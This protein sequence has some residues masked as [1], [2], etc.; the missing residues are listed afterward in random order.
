MS[1]TRAWVLGVVLLALAA[2]PALGQTPEP[3]QAKDA[4]PFRVVEPKGSPAPAAEVSASEDATPDPAVRER[5]IDANLE[6]TLGIYEAILEAERSETLQLDRRIEQNEK[7]VAEYMPQLERADEKLRQLQVNFMKKTFLLKS[8]LEQGDI[9]KDTFN[10]LMEREERKNERY[11]EEFEDDRAFFR[12]EIAR[13]QERLKELRLHRTV[14]ARAALLEG[15][16]SEKAKTRAAIILEDM[17]G[18]LER[19]S[20]FKTRYPMDGS[21]E[22]LHARLKEGN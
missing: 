1:S 11:R 18:L 10:R 13:A 12:D 15:A 9:E 16:G 17:S 6:D 3:E 2:A 7:L 5:Q 22:A 4:G 21:F 14:A 19:L 20:G 8:Q